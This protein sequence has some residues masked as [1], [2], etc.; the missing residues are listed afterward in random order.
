MY[1]VHVEQH[2]Q[3]QCRQSWAPESQSDNV[4]VNM[5]FSANPGVHITVL[6]WGEFKGSLN[7]DGN[8]SVLY[9]NN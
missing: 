4:K 8:S 6:V 2:A 5:T 3:W 9:K 1:L 7:I